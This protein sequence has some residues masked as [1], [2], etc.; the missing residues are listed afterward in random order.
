MSRSLLDINVLLALLDAGGAIV[1]NRVAV[2]VEPGRDVVGRAGI[3][4]DGDRQ[5]GVFEHP[6]RQRGRGR[7]PL[8]AGDRGDRLVH[9][10]HF[11]ATVCASRSK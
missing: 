7:F 4:A 6:S 1:E 3:A 5:S 8:G 11:V 2:V 10:I 9:R